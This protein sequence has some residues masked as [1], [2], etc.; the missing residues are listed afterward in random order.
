MSYFVI[1]FLETAQIVRYIPVIKHLSPRLIAIIPL[2]ILLELLRRLHNDLY[3][4]GMHRLTHL[5]GRLSFSYN[6]PVIKYADIRAINVMQDFWGRVFNYGDIA[7][8]TAAHDGNE[9]VISGVNAPVEL[10]TLLDQL[11][12]QSMSVE[13]QE[14]NRQQSSD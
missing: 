2:L 10:A 11:R 6:V 14:F 5:R 13:A 7:I 3:I 8:G 9:L 12:S 4:F 1:H